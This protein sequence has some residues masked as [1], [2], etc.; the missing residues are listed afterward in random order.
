MGPK[1]RTCRFE[2]WVTC[3]GCEVS[4]LSAFRNCSQP[5]PLLPLVFP[6][7]LSEFQP[8]SYYLPQAPKGVEKALLLRRGE[9]KLGNNQPSAIYI[10]FSLVFQCLSVEMHLFLSCF[11][12]HRI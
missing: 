7:G 9:W 11:G 10:E 4:F 2:V 5:P 12:I 1:G 8:L 6:P 3:Y